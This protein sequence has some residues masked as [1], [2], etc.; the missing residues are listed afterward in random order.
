MDHTCRVVGESPYSNLLECEWRKLTQQR[1]GD[2]D[3]LQVGKQS[4]QRRLNRRIRPVIAEAVA[5]TIL[6]RKSLPGRSAMIIFLPVLRPAQHGL[7]EG[8]QQS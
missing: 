3:S 8:C 7:I 2:G 6:A 4:G 1:Q 5:Q